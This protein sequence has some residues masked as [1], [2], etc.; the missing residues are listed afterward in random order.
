[1]KSGRE[2]EML[3]E[4]YKDVIGA[5]PCKH[6]NRGK[7]LCPFMNSCMYAHLLPDGSKYEYPWKDNKINEYV[8]K[9]MVLGHFEKIFRSSENL[10][11]VAK[12]FKSKFSANE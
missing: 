4:E 9:K 8:D 11:P 10:L 3:I 6:F 5:I 2:K 1:M 7:G 12:T